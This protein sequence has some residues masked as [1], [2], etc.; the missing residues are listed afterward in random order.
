VTSSARALDRGLV[1]AAALVALV[2][3]LPTGRGWSWGS[4]VT[5]LHWYAT[6]WTSGTA[7]VQLLGNLALLGPLA[8]LAVLRWPALRTP[9]RLATAALASGTGIELLQ[10]V[11]P[12]GRVV[13]PMDALLNA[14]G[15][16]LV[17]LVVMSTCRQIDMTP[18]AG[19]GHRGGRYRPAPW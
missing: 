4:P 16:V 10:R 12:L 6:A 18:P 7:M 11:L 15:A 2:T 17:G 14:T 1:A 5:E 19:P 3:L 8:A 13:S 9:G